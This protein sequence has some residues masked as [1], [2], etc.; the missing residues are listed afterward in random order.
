MDFYEQIQAD[1]K[2]AERRRFDPALMEQEGS[3]FSADGSDPGGENAAPC[4]GAAK[5]GA[6]ASDAAEHC[7]A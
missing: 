7:H 6:H 2:E 1:L 5:Q 3:G 4:G